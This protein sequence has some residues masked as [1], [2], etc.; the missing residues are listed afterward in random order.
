M[1]TLGKVFHQD[2]LCVMC[3]SLFK[4]CISL[5]DVCSYCKVPFLYIA[6][7]FSRDLFNRWAIQSDIQIG[8]VYRDFVL[9][10]VLEAFLTPADREHPPISHS[11]QSSP[12]SAKVSISSFFLLNAIKFSGPQRLQGL[13]CVQNQPWCSDHIL[14]WGPQH[15]RVSCEPARPAVPQEGQTSTA[16]LK[17]HP[18]PKHQEVWW[19]R[20]HWGLPWVFLLLLIPHCAIENVL[21]P[22]GCYCRVNSI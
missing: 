21:A 9:E 18:V 10:P 6:A 15:R 14:T 11:P 13:L 4:T 3:L 7:F 5:T 8:D 22:S 12:N 19:A 20:T 2:C 16:W 17:S 1:E